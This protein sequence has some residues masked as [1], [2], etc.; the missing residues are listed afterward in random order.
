VAN[1]IQAVKAFHRGRPVRNHRGQMTL[2]S[3]GQ[4]WIDI[5]KGVREVI[6][7]SDITGPWEIAKRDG[8]FWKWPSE[9][10]EAPDV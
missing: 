3:S 6:R 5:S 4:H 2:T 8:F 10:K 9:V 7:E 1:F